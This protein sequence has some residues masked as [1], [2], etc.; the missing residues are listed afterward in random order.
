MIEARKSLR[1]S[2][3]AWV[4]RESHGRENEQPIEDQFHGKVDGIDD[5]E[6]SRNPADEKENNAK[7]NALA[8]AARPGFVS[9]RNHLKTGPRIIFPVHPGDGEKVG[10]LPE[11]EDGKETPRAGIQ[12]PA[13]GRPADHRRQR[14]WDRAHQGVGRC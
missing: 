9:P 6:E 5:A 1:A 14:S 8:R 12:P 10:Q 11:E 4:R 3:T 13:G 7:E 2:A